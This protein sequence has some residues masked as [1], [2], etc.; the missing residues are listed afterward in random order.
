VVDVAQITTNSALYH[1]ATNSTGL[2]AADDGVFHCARDGV[3]PG[4]HGRYVGGRHVSLPCVNSGEN[5]G[6]D[7]GEFRRDSLLMSWF[8][9]SSFLRER[10]RR[11]ILCNQPSRA[12]MQSANMEHSIS[13]QRSLLFYT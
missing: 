8:W 7:A 5:P 3:D 2:V 12:I 6:K 9:S 10:D 11:H 4:I 1:E 13:I